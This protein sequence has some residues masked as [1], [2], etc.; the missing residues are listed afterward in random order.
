MFPLYA[1]PFRVYV[2][3]SSLDSFSRPSSASD[4]LLCPAWCDAWPNP[5]ALARR[6]EPRHDGKLDLELAAFR[7]PEGLLEPGIWL[8]DH[9]MTS[10]S[11]WKIPARTIQI[12]HANPSA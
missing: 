10:L 9:L 12:R 7:N 11:R 2:L 8:R 5:P 3:I 4:G 1:V 6:Y